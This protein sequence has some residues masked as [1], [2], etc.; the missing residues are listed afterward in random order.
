MPNRRSLRA[1][2]IGLALVTSSAA[3][4]SDAKSDTMPTSYMK[5]MK[6]DPMEVMHLIDKG[7]KGFVTREEFMKFQEQFFN[8]MDR[9]HNGRVS[10]V[11]WTDA[12]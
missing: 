6:M 7:T 5:L 9:D 1:A 10:Q 11:E 12:G 4:A 3:L 2:F 8:K